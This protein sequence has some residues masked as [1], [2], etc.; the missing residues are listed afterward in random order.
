MKRVVS[1]KLLH[2]GYHNGSAPEANRRKGIIKFNNN[3][4]IML[5]NGIEVSL[6]TAK[7]MADASDG[8]IIVSLNFY[9]H[10]NK[11][12]SKGDRAIA[13]YY[14]CTPKEFASIFNTVKQLAP[15]EAYDFI[16]NE[17]G[18]REL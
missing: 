12:P 10:C 6:P 17:L 9:I 2:A 18:G 1:S 13:S 14:S 4:Y 7:V 3:D 15:D 16:L 11:E 5:Q 8:S